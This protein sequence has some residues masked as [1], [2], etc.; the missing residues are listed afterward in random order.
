MDIVRILQW[1]LQWMLMQELRIVNLNPG[2]V[3]SAKPCNPVSAVERSVS[4]VSSSSWSRSRS[5]RGAGEGGC[6]PTQEGTWGEHGWG[7]ISEGIYEV[8][9]GR[10]H[11]TTDLR[12]E[13]YHHRR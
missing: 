9:D 5:R 10:Y 7:V 11:P 4:K 2:R 8:D 6:H 13:G 1:I 12:A 3:K